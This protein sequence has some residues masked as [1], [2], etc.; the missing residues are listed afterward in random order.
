H[1]LLGSKSSSSDI[2]SP[3]AFNIKANVV[4]R[5][6]VFVPTGWDSWGKI[7]VL[8]DGFGCP[9]LLQGW[10]LDMG[11][12]PATSEEH[13]EEIISTKKLYEEVCVHEDIDKV[14]DYFFY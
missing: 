6:T 3:Y 13:T 1:R 14:C 2:K 11:V 5:D 4:E 9:E 10:D 12:K 8:R 7:K